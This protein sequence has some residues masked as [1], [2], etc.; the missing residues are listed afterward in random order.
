VRRLASTAVIAAL[1][2]AGSA[3]AFDPTGVDIIGLHLGM[4][5]S[6]VVVRL[7]SQGYA[8]TR[9]PGAIAANTKDGR[10]EVAVSAEHGVTQITYIFNDH[11][12]GARSKIHEAIMM[13]YGAPDQATPL[14]WCRAVGHDGICPAKQP[15]LTFLPGSLTLQLSSEAEEQQ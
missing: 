15:T 9:A 5:E 1:L 13:R 8:A 3:H 2:A 11:M 14:T 10:V 6:D 4:R 12:V 7:A